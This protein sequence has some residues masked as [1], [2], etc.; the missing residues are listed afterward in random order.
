MYTI[1][2]SVLSIRVGSDTKCFKHDVHTHHAIIM[3]VYLDYI[4][5][6][7]TNLVCSGRKTHKYK[8]GK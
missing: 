1:Y 4:R 2:R 7:N 6:Y 3:H 5:K 8:V